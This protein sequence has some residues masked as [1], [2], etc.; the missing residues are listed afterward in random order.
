MAWLSATVR[1]GS[2]RV[3][4]PPIFEVWDPCVCM[5]FKLSLRAAQVIPCPVAVAQDSLTTPYWT[6]D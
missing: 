5:A 3:R 4:M 2:H 1:V 6:L